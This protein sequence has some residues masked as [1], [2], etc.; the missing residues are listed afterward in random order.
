MGYVFF[1]F[2]SFVNVQLYRLCNI[3]SKKL[4]TKLLPTIKTF[5][6]CNRI[7]FEMSCPI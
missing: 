2:S 6:N 1:I 5:A 3:D 4:T 7:I